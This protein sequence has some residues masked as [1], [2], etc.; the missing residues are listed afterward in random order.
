M[1]S[2]ATASFIFFGALFLLISAI[3]LVR[4]PDIYTR[5]HA[6]TK[7]TSFG[8]L[9]IIIGIAIFFNTGIVW[10]K[11]A[12]V[13]VFIYFTAPLAAHSIAQSEEKRRK[14]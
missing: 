3:G 2:I 14:K 4:F 6:I 5:M 7:A 11:A 13:I 10:L 12:L 8:L 9:L 1:T